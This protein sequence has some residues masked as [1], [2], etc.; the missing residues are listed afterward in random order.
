MYV[1]QLSN[2]GSINSISLQITCTLSQLSQTL[3]RACHF[4]HDK[5]IFLTSNSLCIHIF[6]T[7]QNATCEIGN[8]FIQKAL[9]QLTNTKEKAAVNGKVKFFQVSIIFFM[10][11]F[12]S[13]AYW[14]LPG[15]YL[16]T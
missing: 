13:L 16:G 11:R 7:L 5:N 3:C 9:V 12:S 2:F 6:V 14:G 1:N 8:A 4:F 15:G 10:N